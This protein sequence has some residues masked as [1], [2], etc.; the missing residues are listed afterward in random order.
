MN[1]QESS[2]PE[3]V[4]GILSSFLGTFPVTENRLSGSQIL[5]LSSNSLC[6]V[7]G[8]VQGLL[9]YDTL[10]PENVSLPPQTPGS[11]SL[12]TE[13]AF[14]ELNE[15]LALPEPVFL[16]SALPGCVKFF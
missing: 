10:H 11:C 3:E 6:Q 4:F 1:I 8:K 7:Y 9:I 13:V 15:L 2:S 12:I 5:R 16:Q 14:N